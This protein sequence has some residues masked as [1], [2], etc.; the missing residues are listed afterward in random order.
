MFQKEK[1]CVRGVGNPS[2]LQVREKT[3]T[4]VPI[5]GHD[6]RGGSPVALVIT[7]SGFSTYIYVLPFS[8]SFLPLLLQ[9]PFPFGEY[10]DRKSLNGANFSWKKGTRSLKLVV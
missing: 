1:L 5:V 6:F 2:H 7:L 9:L 3:L 10:Q 8:S 4:H